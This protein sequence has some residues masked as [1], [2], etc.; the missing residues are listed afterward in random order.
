[1]QL[2]QVY[3]SAFWELIESVTFHGSDVTRVA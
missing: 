2:G 3:K 1:M